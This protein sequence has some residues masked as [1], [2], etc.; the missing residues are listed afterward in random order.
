MNQNAKKIIIIAIA[1]L[2]LS[3]SAVL[4][5]RYIKHT[6]IDTGQPHSVKNSIDAMGI[7]SEIG[8]LFDSALRGEKDGR[9]NALLL[10]M[11]G[12]AH[13]SG[14]LTDTVILASFNIERE[15]L[16]LFSIPRDL[17]VRANENNFQKINEL[18]RFAGGTE[19]PDI[20]KINDIK[21]KVRAIA[22]LPVHYTALINFQGVVDI[23]D[24]LGGV[25]IESRQL[26]GKSALTY[27]RDRSTPG[28]DFDRMLRQ[29][30]LIRALAAKVKAKNGAIGET[31]DI[32]K[33]LAALDENFG[34]DASLTNLLRFAQMAQNVKKENIFSHAITSQSGGPLVAEYRNIGE[35]E[36]YILTPKAGLE[37]YSEVQSF[38]QQIIDEQ[39]TNN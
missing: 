20:T 8:T 13:I 11:G 32:G 34:F 21:E 33:L 23:V 27:I 31:A 7:F 18:Y 35:R 6:Y 36:I 2:L 37:D 22:G 14:E 5:V 4:G 12:Q 16:D 38:I 39:G 15:R 19:N 30:E 26:D 1:G 24:A 29:Q 9:I 3:A 10:G 28:G 25:T 17:W